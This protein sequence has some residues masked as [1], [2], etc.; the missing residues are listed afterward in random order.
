MIESNPVCSSCKLPFNETTRKEFQ[1]PD[2]KH[3]FCASCLPLLIP[4]QLDIS[5][6]NALVFACPILNCSDTPKTYEK[7]ARNDISDI[8]FGDILKSPTE[9]FGASCTSHKKPLTLFCEDCKQGHCTKC[10]CVQSGKSVKLLKD[11][12]E[13]IEKSFNDLQKLTLAVDSYLS[14]ILGILRTRKND[15][16][17]SV[18]LQFLSAKKSLEEQENTILD[19]IESKFRDLLTLACQTSSPRVHIPSWLNEMS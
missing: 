5:D 18:K 10:P 17:T 8:S 16:I 4:N 6:P 12:Q 7:I 19:E 3:S 13:E 2:C 11:L 1:H 15:M 9:L 14:S